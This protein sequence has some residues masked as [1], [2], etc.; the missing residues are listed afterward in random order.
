MKI[1]PWD[2]KQITEPGFYANIPMSAYHGGRLCAGPSLSSGS[3]RA[4][5]LR[6]EA[7]FYDQWPL[8][9][10]YD[11]EAGKPTES[12]ILGR[13]AHHLLLG[14]PHFRRE[15]VIEPDETPDA[16]GKMR[17]WSRQF[18][19]AKKWIADKEAE[20]LTVLTQEKA[21]SIK[22]MALRLG[23]EKPIAN[24]ALTGWVE[25]TMAWKDRATG[26]WCLSRPDVIPTDS[27]DF[28][29]LK[30][31]GRG[32]V[33]YKTLVAAIG[34]HGYHMQAALCGEGWMAL[35]GDRIAS[36][37]FYFVETKR[38][39]CAHMVQLKPNDLALGERQ[40]KNARARFVKAMN[41]G[42]WP[43]PNGTQ[44][45][46]SYIDLSDRLRMAIEDDLAR[47]EGP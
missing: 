25:I 30:T 23:R 27:G 2:G 6:S 45:Y 28:C 19:S 21:E 3:H 31:I 33:S 10:N 26:V 38:P 12:M 44:E 4:I 24:G 34:E 42:V 32:I 36:F 13:A 41:S 39:H 47:H 9:P 20:G 22:G 8:N 46:V 11:P 1:I 29:D 37:S 18:D 40:N 5:A 43:G 7:H 15:F 14:Q 16:K 17:P 35:T